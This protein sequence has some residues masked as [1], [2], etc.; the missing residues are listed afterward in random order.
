MLIKENKTEKV[1][2]L[3]Y[4]INRMILSAVTMVPSTWSAIVVSIASG[5]MIIVASR[6]NYSNLLLIT[7]TTGV[8]CR[9][10]A[11]SIVD[12]LLKYLLEYHK[13]WD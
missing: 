3:G 2:V 9:L 13:T 11:F 12:C 1:C 10:S 4:Y 5:M 8:G 6:L 7:L